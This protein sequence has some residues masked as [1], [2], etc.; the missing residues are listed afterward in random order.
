MKPHHMLPASVPN[1]IKLRSYPHTST[2]MSAETDFKSLSQTAGLGCKFCTI[3]KDAILAFADEAPITR[4]KLVQSI[5]T[6]GT[7]DDPNLGRLYPLKVTFTVL[8]GERNELI[9]YT[10]DC[11]SGSSSSILIIFG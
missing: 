1:P 7:D 10:Q 11:E 8:S 9:L 6:R 4:V 2:V 3:V 5:E